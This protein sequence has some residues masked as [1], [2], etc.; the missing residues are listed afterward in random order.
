MR[1]KNQKIAFLI[2]NIPVHIVLDKTQEKLNSID[3]NVYNNVQDGIMEE[4]KK[5]DILSQSD[6]L[7]KFFDDNDSFSKYDFN[8]YE[9]HLYIKDMILKGGLTDHK[10]VDTI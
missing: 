10:I 9:Y 7:R 2:D 4:L 3:I 6:K 8:T 1:R 5:T